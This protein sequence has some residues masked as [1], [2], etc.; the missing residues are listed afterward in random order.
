MLCVI[1]IPCAIT[2]L[3]RADSYEVYN[4]DPYTGLPSLTPSLSIEESDREIRVYE[5][6]K[7]APSARNV[8]PSQVIRKPYRAPQIDL[9]ENPKDNR[10]YYVDP[11][12]RGIEWE[13]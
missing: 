4:T 5:Y 9:G 3:A 1:L 12:A 8:L 7:Y 13:D 2:S 10:I 11:R 6:N